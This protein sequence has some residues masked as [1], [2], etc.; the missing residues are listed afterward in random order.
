MCRLLACLALVWFVGPATACI[1]DIE[2]PTHEREFRS[3]YHGPANP[4]APPATDPS[5]SNHRLPIGA[6]LLMLTGAVVLS[7]TGPWRK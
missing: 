6:G 4:P 3:Q 7:L 2:L 1:N 5:P